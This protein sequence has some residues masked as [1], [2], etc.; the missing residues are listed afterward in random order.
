MSDSKKMLNVSALYEALAVNNGLP[1]PVECLGPAF[2]TEA[3]L[4]VLVR[5]G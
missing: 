2:T 4:Q 3:M 1:V 5:G